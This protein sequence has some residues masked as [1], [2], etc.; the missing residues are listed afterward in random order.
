[1]LI[2]YTRMRSALHAIVCACGP[3]STHVQDTIYTRVRYGTPSGLHGK[4]A[5][6]IYLSRELYCMYRLV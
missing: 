6:T 4:H 5:C 2:D 3:Q 1:M